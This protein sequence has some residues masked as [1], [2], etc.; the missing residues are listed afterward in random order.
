MTGYD[1]DKPITALPINRDLALEISAH[2]YETLGDIAKVDRVTLLRI[3]GVGGRD[4]R[5]L[6]QA[7]GREPFETRPKRSKL[8]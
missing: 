8:V 1:P 6:M 2:G 3:P 5:T 4:Y 7:V